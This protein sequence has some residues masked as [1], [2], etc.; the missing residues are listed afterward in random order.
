MWALTGPSGQKGPLYRWAVQPMSARTHRPP[1]PRS[2]LGPASAAAYT[3]GGRGKQV[4]KRK[5]RIKRK[6]KHGLFKVAMSRAFTWMMLCMCGMRRSIRTSR[7]MTRAL[8]TFFR[9]S[10]S[11]S[12]ASA[13]RLWIEKKQI[14]ESKQTTNRREKWIWLT[15]LKEE[16]HCVFRKTNLILKVIRGLVPLKP[17]FLWNH[18]TFSSK[19]LTWTI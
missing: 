15:K 18:F 17:R 7:S 10:L 14:W 11:S 16:N 6:S 3:G 4:I 19:L 1:G 12:P 5:W 9:T 13:N 8:H 2:H